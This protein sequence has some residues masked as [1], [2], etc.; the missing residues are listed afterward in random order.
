MRLLGEPGGDPDGLCGLRIALSGDALRLLAS[1]TEYL[2]EPMGL[3]TS[4]GDPIGLCI[5]AGELIG[6]CKSFEDVVGISTATGESVGLCI[7]SGEPI[8]LRS[9]VRVLLMGISTIFEDPLGLCIPPREPVGLSGP[10]E[11]GGLIECES[12]GLPIGLWMEFELWSS[13]AQNRS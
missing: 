9:A 3:C 11:A 2:G 7:A 8:G 5:S 12:T 13:P 1:P 10:G 6:L 4:V